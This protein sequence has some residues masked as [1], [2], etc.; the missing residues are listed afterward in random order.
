MRRGRAWGCGRNRVRIGGACEANYRKSGGTPDRG[1]ADKTGGTMMRTQS[2]TQTSQ[3]DDAVYPAQREHI[4][5]GMRKAGSRRN[6]R[7]PEDPSKNSSAPA[8]R[9][10]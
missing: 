9:L 5:E 6:E 3:S 7:N 1:A 2:L 8:A 4:I 10:R